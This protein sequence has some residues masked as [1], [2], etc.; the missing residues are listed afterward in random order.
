MRLWQITVATAA[1]LTTASWLSGFPS[2]LL[3]ELSATTSQNLCSKVFVSGLDPAQ[4]FADHIA[5]EPG[6]FLVAWAVTPDI[7]RVKKEVGT[8]I[9][10]LFYRRSVYAEGRGCTLTY[11][12]YPDPQS[13]SPPEPVTAALPKIAGNAIVAPETPALAAAINQ[14]FTENEPS[15]LRTKAVV[16]V[17]NGRVI[18]ERYAPGVNPS[19]RL[20]G[21]SISKSVVNALIGVLVRDGQLSVTDP[22]PIPEWKSPGDTRAQIT[23]ENLL[24]MNAGFGFDEGGGASAATHMWF[25][26]PDTAHFAALAKLQ[27][28]PGERW[29]YSSRSFSLLSRIVRTRLNADPQAFRDFAWREIFGPLGMSSFTPE[30]DAAGTMMGAQATLATARDWAKFGLLYLNDGVVGGKRILPEGWVKWSTTPTPGSGYGAGFWLNTTSYVIEPWNF[31][32]GIPGAPKDAYMARGYMGQYI[33][34]VPSANLVVVRFGQSRG[35]G[36][37]IESAGALVKNVIAALRN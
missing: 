20:L 30:F 32:W 3:N 9:A 21:H 19:T 27:S 25:A 36:A 1:L 18:G 34:V 2:S 4:A 7:D 35:K 17:H 14:A 15:A 8:T 37:G 16:V 5:P 26:E 12:G 31:R 24:R 10:G 23:V 11:P 13:L 29:G 28:A 33:I 6:V 22:A